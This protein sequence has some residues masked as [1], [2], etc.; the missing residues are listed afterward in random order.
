MARTLQAEQIIR[1]AGIERVARGGAGAEAAGFLAAN[2]IL[3]LLALIG[4]PLTRFASKVGAFLEA[5]AAVRKQRHE[6]ER[7]WAVALQ[8][9]RVMA[10]LSRAMSQSA[11]R[12]VKAI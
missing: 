3:G 12:D 11:A 1:R 5:Q 10:D 2:V 9:A 6:D 7:L 4:R 8:D